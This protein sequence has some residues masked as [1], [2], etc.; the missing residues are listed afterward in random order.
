MIAVLIYVAAIVAANLTVAAF[1][2]WL[3]PINAFLL[4][5]LDLSLRDYL[6]DRWD[7]RWLWPK[8]LAVITAGG[9]ISFALN[10]AAGLIA[11]ASVAAFVLSGIADAAT[12][13]RLRGRRYMVRSNGS[14]MV[15]AAVDSVAF[16][17]IAFG[18]FPLT[19]IALQFAAKVAGGALWS[20]VIDRAFCRNPATLEVEKTS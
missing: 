7:G 18:G 1:G 11:V 19:I 9:A 2:P 12:Y 4:I 10:P 3:S 16:P 15:G 17:M 6:H 8:M 13:H 5:G 14:N 20:L